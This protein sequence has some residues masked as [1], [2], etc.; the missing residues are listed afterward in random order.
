MLRISWNSR[1]TDQKVLHLMKADHRIPHI[2][3]R[4]KLAYLGRAI[5]GEKYF[6]LQI[7]TEGKIEGKS[8]SINNVLELINLIWNQTS[9]FSSE[10]C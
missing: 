1:T 7:I 10:G 2:I 5:R 3:K 8:N 9:D 6:L 4:N